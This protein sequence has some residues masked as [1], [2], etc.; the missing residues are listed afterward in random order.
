LSESNPRRSAKLQMFSAF[1]EQQNVVFMLN[2]YSVLKLFKRYDNLTDRMSESSRVSRI[3]V[4]SL[5]S[6]TCSWSSLDVKEFNDH[7]LCLL[8]CWIIGLKFE[9][10][11]PESEILRP[12]WAWISSLVVLVSSKTTWST[13]QMIATS[14]RSSDK[15]SLSKS[16]RINAV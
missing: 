3:R 7:L 2:A 16:S 14:Q 12:N 11:C 6:S 5:L 1:H 4:L 13:A 9:I 8:C 10:F 15:E